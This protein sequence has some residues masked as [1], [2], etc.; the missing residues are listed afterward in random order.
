MQASRLLFPKGVSRLLFPKSASRLLFP[1]GGQDAPKFSVK[2]IS[3]ETPLPT[4]CS[5]YF[6]TNTLRT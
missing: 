1:K 5:I 3:P 2:N 6:Y 4:T